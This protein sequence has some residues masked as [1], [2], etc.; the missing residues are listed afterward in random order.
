[1]FQRIFDLKRKPREMTTEEAEARASEERLLEAIF[2]TN[3]I[4]TQKAES[5]Q[6]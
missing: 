4:S 2:G 1:M 3:D 5:D 6:N